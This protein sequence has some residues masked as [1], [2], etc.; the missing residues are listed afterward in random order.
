VVVPVRLHAAGFDSVT[1][2]SLYGMLTGFATPFMIAPTVFAAAV[3]TSLVPSVSESAAVGDLEGLRRKHDLG[4][5]FTLLLVLPSAAGLLALARE[6]PA[7]F[8]DSP[9]TG[10][11]L[12]LL[13]LGTLFLG[14]QQ[15]TSAF[16]YGVGDAR[17]P[18]RSLLLGALVKLAATWALTGLPAVHVNGAALGTSSGFLVAAWLNLR[19]LEARLGRRVDWAAIGGKV[20]LASVLMAVLARLLFLV[21]QPALGLKL[22]TLIA[23]AG[24]AVLYVVALGLVGGITARELAFIPGAGPWLARILRRLGLLRG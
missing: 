7:T 16:L 15:T 22:S 20:L 8:F 5:R 17:V 13:A 23:V 11:P 12:A 24:G 1:A 4:L 3:A 2:T 14:L 10:G 6:I 18:V 19:H 9:E 21:L